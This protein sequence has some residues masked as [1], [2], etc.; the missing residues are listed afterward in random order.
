MTLTQLEYVLVLNRVRQF[1]KA[2]LELNITQPTL[3]MQLRKLEEEIGIVLFDRTK[4]PILPTS[5]GESFIRQTQ[6]VLKQVRHLLDIT[7]EEHE[8]S[9]D[10]SIG[11]I[12]SLSPYLLPLFLKGFT[13]AYPKVSL[14]IEE[15]QT[16]ELVERL[17]DD[18]LDAGI[19]ATPLGDSGLIE[20]V[21]F[22]EEYLAFLSKDHLLLKNKTLKSSDLLGYPIWLLEDGHCMR[23]QVLSLCSN[24]LPDHNVHFSGGSLETLKNLVSQGNGMTILPLLA[25]RGLEASCLRNFEGKKPMREI[26]L[27]YSRS[28]LKERYLDGLEK[29]IIEYLPYD[30]AS[31]KKGTMKILK[32]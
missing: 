15:L 1:T 22:Y 4:S 26:S 19:L 18:R 13:V 17:K 32:I 14:K 30:L 28:F 27:I 9:G 31:P 24:K 7:R 20:R 21:L 8:L 11:I 25:A 10:F 23:N 29:C 2:A 16:A 3:S 12:P 6:V 5:E